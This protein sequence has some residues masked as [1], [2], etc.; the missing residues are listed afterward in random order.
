MKTMIV[1]LIAVAGVAG[2]ANAQ[3]FP[4]NASLA[5]EAWNGSSWVRNSFTAAP[6]QT[7]VEVR[8]VVDYSGP[9][10]S[11]VALSSLRYQPVLGNADLTGASQDSFAGWRNGGVGGDLVANSMLSVA[12]GNDGNAL[13]SYGRVGFGS[14]A[15]NSG[16][17]NVITTFRHGGDFPAA[18]F[19]GTGAA[20]RVAGSFVSTFPGTVDGPATAD[21]INRIN[22]GLVASQST[23]LI[24][25]NPNP[26]YRSGLTGLVI[27]RAA[28]LLGDSTATR[29]LSTDDWSQ[30]RFGSSVGSTDNRRFSL[31]QLNDAETVGSV[32][33]DVNHIPLS[34]VIPS[35][36]SMALLGLGGLAAA[37]R[38]R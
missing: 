1:S 30:A 34:I 24:G 36:A 27:F 17:L 28:I 4:S 14:V 10:G 3:A 2:I 26:N 12:E 18:G 33:V 37:R 16:S 6:G 38:R 19:T 5:F 15:T 31:W 13:A 21:D 22:R 11:A 8:A 9:A 29:T 23:A 32:R 7:R 25:G 35:P 20:L